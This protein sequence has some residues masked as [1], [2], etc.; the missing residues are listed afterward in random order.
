MS[1]QGTVFALFLMAV[2]PLLS[3]AAVAAGGPV[4]VAVVVVPGGGASATELG[5]IQDAVVAEALTHSGSKFAWKLLAFRPQPLVRSE[6]EIM[7]E[8]R[9]L[10]EQGTKAYRYMKLADAEATFERAAALLR[11]RPS[12]RCKPD[13]LAEVYLYWARSVL[14]GGDEIGAQVLLGQI[15]RFDPKAVPDPAVMPPNLVATFDL[16]M[17]DRRNRPAGKLLFSVGPA[18]GRMAVD[19][20][21]LTTGLVEY[22]SVGGDEFWLAAEINGGHY[23]NRFVMPTG[24]RREL[25]IFS[26]QPG[27]PAQL[28]KRYRSLGKRSV[29][30]M[31]LVA[32]PDEDLDAM[33][34]VLGVGVLVVGGRV[35]SVSG[36]VARLGLYVPRSGVLGKPVDVVLS[37]SGQPDPDSLAEGLKA[38]AQQAQ[39]PT[40]L[41]ALEAGIKKPEP[42]QVAALGDTGTG[43]GPDPD[44]VN[45]PDPQAAGTPWW[46]TWWFWTATGVVVAGAAA[47]GVVLG[48]GA[49]ETEPSGKVVLGISPL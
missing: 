14:D 45:D 35:K 23:A 40:L 29:A 16:A 26:G 22:S 6:Q 20:Q 27:D 28:T 41:A 36:G 9:A 31:G 15:L 48:M 32:K 47:T 13:E 30:V 17:D 33:A 5:L 12:I 8:F 21:E 37:A 18:A 38:L 39:N 44:A 7:V 10:A 42:E 1:R 4:Q 3:S 24:K 49:G 25:Q 11:S 43:S 19:C 34:A 46:Q 2:G